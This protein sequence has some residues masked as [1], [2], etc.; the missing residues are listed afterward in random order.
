MTLVLIGKGLVLGGW[1]SKI[2]VIW[3][4]GIY[5]FLW[6]FH[7][8]HLLLPHFRPHLGWRCRCGRCRARHGG[9]RG[10]AAEPSW[11]GV[12]GHRRC[13]GRWG[14][15]NRGSKMGC[16]LNRW[17]FFFFFFGGG[18]P[19]IPKQELVLKSWRKLV[20]GLHLTQCVFKE[21]WS[22]WWLVSIRGEHELQCM[23]QRW[24]L[25]EM[26]LKHLTMRLLQCEERREFES[27]DEVF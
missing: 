6:I 13:A 4:P 10:G 23:D 26:S 11:L 8:D 22:A 12:G 24:Q 3:V 16:V 21:M 17:L 14:G 1:P 15:W 18:Y 19:N 9:Q 20:V 27:E 7:G 5:I 2:E 25:D